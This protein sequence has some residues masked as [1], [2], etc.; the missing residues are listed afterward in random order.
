MT[1]KIA[2]INYHKIAQ[3]DN[4]EEGCTGNAWLVDSGYFMLEFTS[5][6]DFKSKLAKWVSA[7]FDVGEND[8]YNNVENEIENNRFDYSQNEDGASSYK[9]IDEN[10]TDGYL[11]DYNFWVEVLQKIDYKF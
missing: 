9:K 11:C 4:Y 3:H 8:F 2:R 7:R 10:N 6:D 1:I 5:T